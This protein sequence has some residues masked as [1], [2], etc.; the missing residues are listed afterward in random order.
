MDKTA[1]AGTHRESARTSWPRVLAQ[2]RER[3]VKNRRRRR[4]R[5]SEHDEPAN[6]TYFGY[7]PEAVPVF[8]GA[9]CN[10][11]SLRYSENR[12]FNRLMRNSQQVVGRTFELPSARISE[13]TFIS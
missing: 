7:S 13:K 3:G 5:W 10:L 11:G 1:R 6:R 9:A 12:Y 8:R 4:G 2:A